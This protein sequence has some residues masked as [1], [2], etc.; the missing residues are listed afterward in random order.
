MAKVIEFIGYPG[1]GKTT[2]Y[3]ELCKLWKRNDVWIPYSKCKFPNQKKSELIITYIKSLRPAVRHKRP[4]IS[5]TLR[6]D[7]LSRFVNENQQFMDL[8]LAGLASEGAEMNMK[9]KRFWIMK[10]LM[11]I[12][13]KEQLSRDIDKYSYCVM[14]EALLQNV[15][16]TILKEK[17][18]EEGLEKV[19]KFLGI[20]GVVFYLELKKEIAMERCLKRFKIR[21]G[22]SIYKEKSEKEI[23]LEYEKEYNEKTNEI[24][25]KIK[26]LEHYRNIQLYKI[27]AS[28]SPVVNA[29]EM[30]YIL[31]SLE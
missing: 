1:A 17:D 30:K 6:E 31:D 7:A 24:S 11:T 21:K 10:F 8:F 16:F 23:L 14:D 15:R 9:N 20:E 19:V 13:V 22:K 26:V 2:T 29:K 3:N 25:K 28:K 18:Y 4:L 5:K 27:D 12:F